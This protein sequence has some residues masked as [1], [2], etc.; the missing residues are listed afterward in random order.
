MQDIGRLEFL[1]A[2]KEMLKRYQP[3]ADELKEMVNHQ[4]GPRIYPILFCNDRDLD[5]LRI[6]EVFK[7][8]NEAFKELSN[9]IE[10]NTGLHTGIVNKLNER[11]KSNA[12]S[13]NKI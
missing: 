10:K 3:V 9:I 13:R 6:N 2:Y 4:L 8:Q 11:K 7:T 1:H 12:E 5:K